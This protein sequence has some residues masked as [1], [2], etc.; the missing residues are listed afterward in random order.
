VGVRNRSGKLGS[1]NCQEKFNGGTYVL[2]FLGE[3]RELLLERGRDELLAVGTL[4]F[5]GKKW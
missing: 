2:V 5:L 3:N 1:R 4:E